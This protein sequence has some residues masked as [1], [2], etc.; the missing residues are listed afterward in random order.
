MDNILHMEPR[1]GKVMDITRIR[2][3]IFYNKRDKYVQIS[4]GDENYSI[5]INYIREIAASMDNYGEVPPPGD[6]EWEQ[7]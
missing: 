1:E 4:I 3:N 5:A 7:L 6:G 2:N